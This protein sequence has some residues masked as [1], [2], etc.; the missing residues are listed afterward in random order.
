LMLVGSQP[1]SASGAVL[2]VLDLGMSRALFHDDN[3]PETFELTRPGET[4]GA[5]DYVSPEQARDAHNVDIRADVYSLG[6][7]LYHALAGQPPFTDTS[8]VRQLMR[9]QTEPPQPLARL[10][11]AVPA[12]L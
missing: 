11:P 3:D 6:C 10:N 7:V 5:A 2:K 1:D 8:R 12:A 4:L 9:H